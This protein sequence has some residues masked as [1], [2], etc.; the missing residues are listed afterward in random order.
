MYCEVLRHFLVIYATED[1]LT[2]LEADITEFEPTGINFCG[3]AAL[4][5]KTKRIANVIA[6]SYSNL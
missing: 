6:Y 5:L 1:F 3:L 4:L 2:E